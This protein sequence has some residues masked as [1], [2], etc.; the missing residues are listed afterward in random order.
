MPHFP[1]RSNPRDL[2]GTIRSAVA[3][4]KTSSPPYSL[5]VLATQA[6]VLRNMPIP[7]RY[8]RAVCHNH[9][10]PKS[11]LVSTSVFELFLSLSLVYPSCRRRLA[12]AH[13]PQLDPLNAVTIPAL[14]C[15]PLIPNRSRKHFAGRSCA[16]FSISTSD[17][18]NELSMNHS[19]DYTT[20]QTRR[21]LYDLSLYRWLG[22]TQ[23]PIFHDDITSILPTCN[24]LSMIPYIDDVLYAVLLTRYVLTAGS[25]ETHPDTSWYSS[26]LLGNTFQG[27]KSS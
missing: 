23:Y 1:V 4:A 7:A 21:L 26:T 15:T 19:R 6:W 9:P 2:F 3:S 5:P 20:F 13:R 11:M 12:F 8:L 25:Y 17:T 10:H 16:V 27:F 22:P 24:F 18:T 14:G